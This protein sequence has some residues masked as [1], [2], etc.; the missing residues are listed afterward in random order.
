MAE[1]YRE[2]VFIGVSNNDTVA[3]GKD[4]AATFD[5]PYPLAHGPEVWTAY[6][7]PF[8]P[9][10]VVISA[11]GEIVERFIGEVTGDEVAAVLEKLV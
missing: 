2:V 10:T 6:D 11:E 3:D 5:V 9:T 1:E 8:R 4:Y 7:D